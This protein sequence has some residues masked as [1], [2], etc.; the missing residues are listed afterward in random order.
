MENE[1]DIIQKNEEGPKIIFENDCPLDELAAL[2][3]QIHL[4]KN[5]PCSSDIEYAKKR[6]Q[7]FLDRLNATELVLRIDGELVGS[8]F[9]FEETEE[10]LEKEIPYVNF[11]T[12]P[13]ERVFQIKGV[14]IKLKYRGQGLGQKITEQII[15]R[16]RQKGATKIILSTPGEKDGPA[17][18]LYEKLGFK[19]VAPDQ[20]PQSFYMVREYELK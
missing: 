20:S 4:E 17:Q 18:K 2:A 19:E 10:E 15:D 5:K 6:L 1:K 8:A 16:T 7:G 13:S 12:R 9:S 11:F 3:L 14:N